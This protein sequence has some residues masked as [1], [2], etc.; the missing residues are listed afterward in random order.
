MFSERLSASWLETSEKRSWP[1]CVNA[2]RGGILGDLI[3][4]Y[5]NDDISRLKR[6]KGSIGDLLLTK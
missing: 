6:Q 1:R 3:R 5:K 4:A 2:L